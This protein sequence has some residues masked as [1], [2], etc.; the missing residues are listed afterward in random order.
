[1]N[2]QDIQDDIEKVRDLLAV[3][4]DYLFSLTMKQ[5]D[6]VLAV[7]EVHVWRLNQ[8][9]T[10][11]SAHITVSETQL[12]SFQVLARSATECFHA[13]GIHSVTLQ[14]ELAQPTIATLD[15]GADLGERSADLRKRR[16]GGSICVLRCHAEGCV[17]PTCCD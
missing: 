16:S 11:A 17:S 10:L 2:P 13:Y 1:M 15:E 8:Q 9:K 5:L 6:G 12:M 7:H 3:I 14:P 4:P